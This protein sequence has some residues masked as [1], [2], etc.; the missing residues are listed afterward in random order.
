MSSMAIPLSDLLS[1]AHLDAS[2]W[3]AAG[4]TPVSG[5]N[6][7][8]RRVQAGHGFFAFPGAGQD[9]RAFASDALA[10]GAVAI[11]SETPA[12][13][14]FSG[15]WIPVP[16]GRRALALMSRRLYSS[17]AELTLTGITG[18]NGKTTTCYLIDAI[19]RG[20]GHVTGQ[21][22]TIEYHVAGEVRKAVNTTP[23][24]LDLYRLFD[25]LRRRGGSHATMEVSSHALALGR[26]WGLRFTVAVFTNL[27]QDHL[28]FHRTMDGYFSAKCELFAGQD[29]A[30]PAFAVLNAD[31]EWVGR[32]QPAASTRAI[33]YG[34]SEC[35]TLRAE[36]VEM[37]FAGLRFDAMWEGRRTPVRSVLT[38]RFNLYNLL[39]AFGAGLAHGIEPEQIAAAIASRPAVPGRFEAVD[40]GQPFLVVVDYSHTDDALRNAIRVA[41]ALTRGRVITMFGCGGDRDRAKRP[42]MGQAAGE[43]SDV[44]ILTSDNPRSE[45]PIDIINDALVGLRRTD[46]RHSIELD[47]GRA[48]R[49]AIGEARPGDVV[50]L[51]GKGHEDYQVLKD[52]TLHFDD[53]EEAREALAER[54]FG[55]AREPRS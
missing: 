35:A 8:S 21:V 14:D 15:L 12:P 30:P 41:R 31:D 24:S 16:H 18:T 20:A 49:L 46:T 42:L 44:V 27:T 36:N 11:F 52:R 4:S 29:A 10:R 28:D 37:D 38:G 33:W 53:R 32:V 1:A 55:K 26:V 17:V 5:I 51:A 54:G 22:G 19:L 43:L 45:D 13:A 9:G 7:D 34:M 6:Y 50:L 25:E 40:C 2:A 39:A 3:A 47:R 48:I 23:E